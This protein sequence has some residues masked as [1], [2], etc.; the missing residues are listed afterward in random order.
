MV[1]ASVMGA[2]MTAERTAAERTLA[3]GAALSDV[4]VDRLLDATM[5]F[6]DGGLAALRPA[7]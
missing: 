5:A 6:I 4:E 7:T 3:S 1:A 2:L